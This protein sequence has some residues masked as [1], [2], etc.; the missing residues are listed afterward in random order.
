MHISLV[1]V[2]LFYTQLADSRWKGHPYGL[3]TQIQY[4]NTGT[5]YANIVSQ[6]IC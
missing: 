2:Y 3:F 4:I 6:N 1:G 5:K